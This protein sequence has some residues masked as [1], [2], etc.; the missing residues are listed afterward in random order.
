[1][2]RH[3]VMWS[4]KP[5]T[6]KEQNEF[7][8][9]LAALKGQIEVIRE[10]T[11]ARN[12]NPKEDYDAILIADF[13]SMEDLEEKRLLFNGLEGIICQNRYSKIVSSSRIAPNAW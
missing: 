11:V 6:E 1:M 2:I 8:T 3:V 9:G 13:D 7:L 4:F 5:G 10:C 12:C